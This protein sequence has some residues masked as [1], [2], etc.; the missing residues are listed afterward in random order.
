VNSAPAGWQ[1]YLVP[2]VQDIVFLGVFYLAI[3]L[4]PRFLGDG[5]PGKHILIGEQIIANRS[6]QIYNDFSY[7]LSGLRIPTTEWLS[8]LIYAFAHRLADLDGVVLL[9]AILV[10]TTFTLIFRE[11]VSGGAYFPV[12]AVL[13]LW[14]VF[15]S[16]FHWLA[17]PHLITWLLLAI[18]TPLMLR[19]ARGEPVRLWV[20]PLLMLAWANLHGGFTLGILVWGACLAGWAYRHF[21]DSPRPP[22]KI[23]RDLLIVGA[24]STLATLLNPAGLKLWTSVFGHVGASGLMR[25]HVEWQSPNFHEFSTLPFLLFLAWLLFVLALAGRRLSLELSLLLAGFTALG[26]YSVRNAPYLVIV[27]LP[28]CALLTSSILGGLL[29]GLKRAEDNIRNRE[30]SLRGILWPV[31]ISFTVGVTLLAGHP[32]DAGRQGNRFDPAL[33]PARA[34]DW[35]EHHPQSGNM[36]NHFPWGGYILYREWPDYRVFID[37]QTEFYGAELTEE[38]ASVAA[39]SGDWQGVLDRHQID[40]LIVPTDSA[41]GRLAGSHPE[42]KV[43]YEDETATILRRADP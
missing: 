17:R 24:T 26:L 38:Y 42:W 21:V 33:F 18:W 29:P 32:L 37:G 28:V 16:L 40:W 20:F 30:S 10:A 19:L 27:G 41:L 22:P 13:V 9:A 11:S 12:A 3:L 31:V 35:L 2:K 23:L 4:G 14:G 15:A 25:L 1:R 36:F 39:L 5:D 43:L 34:M 6:P 7:T 8:E